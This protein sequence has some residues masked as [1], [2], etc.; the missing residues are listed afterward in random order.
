M[1]SSVTGDLVH[2]YLTFRF[3]C[4]CATLTDRSV[5]VSGDIVAIGSDLLASNAAD[6]PKHATTRIAAARAILVLVVQKVTSL[7]VDTRAFETSASAR[8]QLCR[9]CSTLQQLLFRCDTTYFP[10]CSIPNRMHTEAG[11]SVLPPPLHES[12]TT[13]D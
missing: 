8:L 6:S 7:I 5:S 1:K 11:V 10:S 9:D 4:S 13:S 3:L 2:G 12:A